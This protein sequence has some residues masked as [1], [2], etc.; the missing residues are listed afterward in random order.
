MPPSKPLS[1]SAVL[2]NANSPDI[3]ETLRTSVRPF[4][5]RETKSGIKHLLT[6]SQSNIPLL[7]QRVYITEFWAIHWLTD[8]I[9]WLSLFL[10]FFFFCFSKRG[11]SA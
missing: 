6:V 3:P 10:F 4:G 11:F 8:G 5:P 2:G 9:M 7:S 1:D